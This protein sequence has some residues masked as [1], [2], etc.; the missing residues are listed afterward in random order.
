MTSLEPMGTSRVP[1][2][3]GRSRSTNA[4]AARVGSAGQTATERAPG[5][6]GPAPSPGVSLPGAALPSAARRSSPDP[7]V[8]TDRYRLNMPF[9]DRL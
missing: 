5:V 6:H 1:Q 8:E 2:P 4:D 3:S 7:L 9:A